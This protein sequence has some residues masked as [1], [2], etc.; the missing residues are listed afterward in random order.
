M[1][2]CYG[3]WMNSNY[4]ERKC[5]QCGSIF[6]VRNCYVK[7]GQGKFCSTG[8]GT[9]YRN[10]LSNP[11]R[12]PEVRAKISLNHADVSG[13]NNPM[14][15]RSGKAAPAWKD[16]RHSFSSATW[17]GV[18]LLRNPKACEV[19]GSAISG[20]R[21]HVHHKDK[22]RANNDPSNLVVTCAGCHNNVFHP[23]ERD[24]LGRFITL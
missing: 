20:R 10:L 5:M 13:Q 24:K 8:C 23:R 19:C 12:R 16:G 18:V 4:Q 1:E 7:R 14:Y 11:S 15:G 6:S 2:V 21:L 22:D 17:R 9:T 3:V